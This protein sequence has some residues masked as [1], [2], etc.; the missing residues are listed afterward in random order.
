MLQ[1]VIIYYPSFEKGGVEKI[2]LNVTKE[3][4]KKIEVDIV[5]SINK[6]LLNN[7]T[8]VFKVKKKIV[9]LIQH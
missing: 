7:K 6:K 8:K 3:F 2:L 5:S 1:K 9:E 4:E